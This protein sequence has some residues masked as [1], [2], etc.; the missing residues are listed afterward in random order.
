[1]NRG[2]LLA[3]LTA[4]FVLA[5]GCAV[6]FAVESDELRSGS[7]GGNIALTDPEATDQVA[8]RV[9]AALK[10]VFS[11]D[12]ANLDRTERA[13]DLALTGRAAEQYRAE[14]AAAAARAKRAKLVRSTTVRSIGVRQL[15][16]RRAVL[17]VFLDQQTLAAG[18]SPKSSTATLDV[19]AVR[20]PDGW[21]ISTIE[22]L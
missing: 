15:T 10:T 11:Y 4:V 9:G 3:A 5:T 19:T 7:S 17:L 12:Y 22:S 16:D 18:R 8:D 21:R 2:R 1:M 14:F 6:W 20:R 13:V